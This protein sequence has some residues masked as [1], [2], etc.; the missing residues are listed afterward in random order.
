MMLSL[1][2]MSDEDLTAVVSYLRSKPATAQQ[3]PPESWGLAAKAL[4]GSFAPR[5]RNPPAAVPAGGV[6]VARGRYLAEGPAACVVCHTQMD[7]LTFQTIGVPFAGN[8]TAEPD[9][10]NE[11]YEF[12]YPNLTPDPETG[13]ITGW[14]EETFL[15]RFRGGRVYEASTMPW[16][17]FAR[18]TDD[19]VRSLY[20][21]LRSLPPT[22]NPVGPPHRKIGG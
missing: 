7:A 2:P 1:G 6:S 5:M 8:T 19:D 9:A 4:S 3:N 14:D 22:R 10:A 21:F 20:R 16:E 11:G 15:R 13:H 18:L 12:V 17:N